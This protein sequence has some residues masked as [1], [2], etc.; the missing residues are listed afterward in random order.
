MI[1]TNRGARRKTT[2]TK[3]RWILSVPFNPTLASWEVSHE[4]KYWLSRS[5]MTDVS[6]LQGCYLLGKAWADPTG[7][8]TR[9]TQ[10]IE[11]TSRGGLRAF[12]IGRQWQLESATAAEETRHD[13][14]V[15]FDRFRLEDVCSL[16][17][18]DVSLKSAVSRNTRWSRRP[19]NQRWLGQIISYRGGKKN[20]DRRSVQGSTDCSALT[21]SLN[22]SS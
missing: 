8:E 13:G 16:F 1:L 2:S 4:S 21:Q 19:A 15:S 14:L 17:L 7:P 3:L 5:L 22:S 6:G 12:V 20:A 18:R 11:L 10:K 9:D